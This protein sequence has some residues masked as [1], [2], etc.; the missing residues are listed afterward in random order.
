MPTVGSLIDNGQGQVIARL[1]GG[2]PG[3][4]TLLVR[5]TARSGAAADQ[6]I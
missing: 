1:P 2:Q 5:K 6:Q 4:E 3:T